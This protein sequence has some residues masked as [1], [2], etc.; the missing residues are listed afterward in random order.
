MIQR[1]TGQLPD[2]AR[3]EHPFLRY[4]LNSTLTLP[5][6]ARYLRALSGVLLVLALLVGGYLLATNLLRQ[7]PGQNPTESLLNVIF[8]PLLA[9]QLL[10]QVGTL[11]LTGG[12]VSDEK[13]RQTWDNV[14][15]TEAGA[16]LAIR[17]RWALVFYRMRALFVVVIG[18]RVL[19]IAGILVDLMA[20]QGRYL[21]LMINGIIPDVALPV[22]AVLLALMMTAGLLLPVTGVGFDAAVG[23]LIATL[24]QERAYTVL[25]QIVLVVMRVLLVAVLLIAA[26]QFVTGNLAMP[27][28]LS[29]VLMFL[30][31]AYGDWGLAFL[32]LG[33][34]GEM[35]ALIPFGVLFGLALLGFALL[36][37]ALTD[38]L[39]SLATR[40]AER[41]G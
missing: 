4:R 24:V 23:L 38:W 40:Q 29:W 2:W 10:M 35:W 9:L 37:A 36:Q 22:A 28:P 32:N 7:P 26:T 14:R 19:L 6:R 12:A 31:A 8:W 11:V 16:G 33:F 34:Y 15:A 30:Y 5:R 3:P 41:Q 25:V 17:S 21:D 20:F 18:L 13:R 27:E 39:L 1:L